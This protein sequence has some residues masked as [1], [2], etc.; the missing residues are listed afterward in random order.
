MSIKFNIQET[1]ETELYYGF[2]AIYIL[3][4][5]HIKVDSDFHVQIVNIKTNEEIELTE[6]SLKLRDYKSDKKAVKFFAFQINEYAKFKISVHNYKDIVVKDS[7]LEF[8]PFPF[9]I[10]NIVKSF[11]T[12]KNRAN[13]T[14]N[15]IEILIE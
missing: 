15:S 5:H 7:I 2:Y 11:I 4:G 6:K 3:G 14:L 9:N 10:P 12:G 1:I 13:K 8:F